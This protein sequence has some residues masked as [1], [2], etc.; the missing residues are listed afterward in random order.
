MTNKRVLIVEDEPA[1]AEAVRFLLTRAGLET[2]VA[3]DGKLALTATQTSRLDLILIDLNLP[4]LSGLD[5]I[6]LIRA[7]ALNAQTPILVLT[8]RG[9]ENDRQR[10]ADMGATAFMAKP[11]QNDALVATVLALIQGQPMATNAA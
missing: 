6:R 7:Q 5:L 11:F 1:I 2:H 8:A 3:G 4:K 10:V 9:Q